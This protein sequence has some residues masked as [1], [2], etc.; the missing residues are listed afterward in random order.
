VAVESIWYKTELPDE[1]IDLIKDECNFKLNLEGRESELLG[2]NINTEIRNSVNAW[3]PTTNWIAGYL[4]YYISR[5]NR[6]TFLYDLEY[7]DGEQIQVTSYGVNEYYGWHVDGGL[8]VEYTPHGYHQNRMK[9]AD[10]FINEN[11]ER[12]RKLSFSLQLS[13]H[14]DYKGGQLQLM[15]EVGETYFAPKKKGT[16]IIFDSRVRHRVR[17]VTEGERQ[18]L[19]G[20]VMGPRWR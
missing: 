14:D 10:D 1:I 12:V 4:W 5:A 3:L 7:I 13:D 20:W 15:N 17:K 19:V 2:G 18:S 8:G 16:L 6:E 11:I 9:N